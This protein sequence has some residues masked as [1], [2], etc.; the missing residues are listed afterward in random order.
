MYK[1]KYSVSSD[2]HVADAAVSIS[3]S[4]FFQLYC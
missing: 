3:F 4:S 2:M 1:L